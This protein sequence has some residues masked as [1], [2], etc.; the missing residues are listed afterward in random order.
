[1]DGALCRAPREEG[2]DETI[3][4]KERLLKIASAFLRLAL[5]TTA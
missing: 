4:T 3:M 1:M 2:N 5:G